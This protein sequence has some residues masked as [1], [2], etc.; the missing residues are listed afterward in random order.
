VGGKDGEGGA[1]KLPELIQPVQVASGKMCLSKW[2]ISDPVLRKILALFFSVAA[3]ES[4]DSVIV[5]HRVILKLIILS[6]LGLTTSSFWKIRLD[7]CSISE[8]INDNG[9]FIICRLNSVAHLPSTQK[10]PGDF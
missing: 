5:T 8:I 4:K 3:T 10:E 9:N 7:T 2:G 1:E 6:A